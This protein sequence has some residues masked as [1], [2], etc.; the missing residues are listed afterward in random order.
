VFAYILLVGVPVLGLLGI[1]EAGR[2]IVAPPA[3]GGEWKLEFDPAANCATGLA[4]LR[5]PAL[6]ISQSGTEALITVNDGRGAVFPATVEGATLRAPSLTATI[7]GKPR[8]RVME[9]KMDF[10]GCA[11]VAFRAVRQA[12]PKKGGE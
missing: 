11:P 6:S 8:E 12:P 4:S 2:A 10:A 1:L 9:G 7:T 5:Q 3:I